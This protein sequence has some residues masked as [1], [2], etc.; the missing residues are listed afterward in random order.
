MGDLVAFGDQYIG[1]L[2]TVPRKGKWTVQWLGNDDEDPWGAHELC[3]TWA[4][5]HDGFYAG[6]QK[7]PDDLA[8]TCK[9]N[10]SDIRACGF[11]LIPKRNIIPDDVFAACFP[12]VWGEVHSSP[13]ASL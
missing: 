3:W 10:R 2:L 6:E 8:Y 12:K 5:D 7:S 1:R 9:I 11:A 4:P 13:C